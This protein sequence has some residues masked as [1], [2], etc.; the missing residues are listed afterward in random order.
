[1]NA[2]LFVNAKN[3]VIQLQAVLL[4]MNECPHILVLQVY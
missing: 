1:M 2:E 4:H 3:T